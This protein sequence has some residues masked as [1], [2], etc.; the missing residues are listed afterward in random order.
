MLEVNVYCLFPINKQLITRTHL[1][2]VFWPNIFVGASFQILDIQQ[3]ACGLK[4]GPA[5]ILNQNPIF[6]MGSNNA[7]V[8]VVPLNQSYCF[9]PHTA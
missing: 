3:Y 1:K 5:A 2:N 9:L 7:P 4:L 8:E 6:E